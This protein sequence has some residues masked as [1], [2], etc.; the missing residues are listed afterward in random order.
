M[1]SSSYLFCAGSTEVHVSTKTAAN[2]DLEIAPLLLVILF[3]VFLILVIVEIVVG[4]FVLI[5]EVVIAVAGM[6]SSRGEDATQ[7]LNSRHI[8]RRQA[9]RL[10]RVPLRRRPWRRRK[11][12]NSPFFSPAGPI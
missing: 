2:T 9:H 10:R 3:F 11:A 8:P 6:V 12:D 5:L 4:V 7:R 1:L